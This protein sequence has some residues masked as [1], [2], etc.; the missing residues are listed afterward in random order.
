M[1]RAVAKK[2]VGGD[3]DKSRVKTQKASKA[4][5]SIRPTRVFGGA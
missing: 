1:A 4:E 3:E 5:V 2:L